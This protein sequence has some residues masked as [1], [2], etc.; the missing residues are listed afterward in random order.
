[1]KKIIL[2]SFLCLLILITGCSTTE[3]SDEDITNIA[4]QYLD[5]NTKK[6]ILD[7]ENAKVD[8][9][10]KSE[11]YL[12]AGPNGVVNT[13]G[14]NIYTITFRTNNEATLGPI[15]VAMDKDTYSIIGVGLRD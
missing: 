10:S 8:K 7:W 1:M 9:E 3:K 4:Y 6:T 14:K 2:Y 5:E 13:K 15:S 12:V 11:G